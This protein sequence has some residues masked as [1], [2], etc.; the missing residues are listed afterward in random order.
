MKESTLE[1][2]GMIQKFLFWLKRDADLETKEDRATA[3]EAADALDVQIDFLIETEN[4]NDA[5]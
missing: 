5:D 4:K 3:I 2:L 1:L